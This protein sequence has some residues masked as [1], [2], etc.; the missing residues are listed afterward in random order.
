MLSLP[1]LDVRWARG[2]TDPVLPHPRYRIT[3]EKPAGAIA[4]TQR[5]ENGPL[6]WSYSLP[7]TCRLST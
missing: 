2:P 1:S 6:E 7:I 5:Q 4:G 3:T